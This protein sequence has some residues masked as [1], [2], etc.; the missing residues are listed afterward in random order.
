MT[1]ARR[2]AAVID[3]PQLPFFWSQLVFGRLRPEIQMNFDGTAK[4][5]CI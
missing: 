4:P 5:K 1:S 3:S 2:E